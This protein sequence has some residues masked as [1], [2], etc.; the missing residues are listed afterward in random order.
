MYMQLQMVSLHIHKINLAVGSLRALTPYE[1]G[2]EYV[3]IDD[4]RV[5]DCQAYQELL[6]C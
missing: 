4:R 5:P 6:K 2:I 3:R 1:S